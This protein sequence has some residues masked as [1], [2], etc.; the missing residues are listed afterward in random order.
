MLQR[1]RGYTLVEMVVVVLLTTFVF[2]A[3]GTFVWRNARTSRATDRKL[4]AIRAVHYL[5][6]RIRRDMK[7]ALDFSVGDGGR[8]L[9][10]TDTQRQKRSYVYD[11]ES[12]TLRVPELLDPA[13]STIYDLAKFR[14]VLFIPDADG[15]GLGYV[16]SAVPF[17]DKGRNL[18]VEE[19][20]WGSA[21]AGRVTLAHRSQGLHHPRA[22]LTGLVP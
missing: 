21:I 2:G 4:Q 22:N 12:R 18:S 13:S 15:A 3:I 16:I 7:G 10:I 8:Q 14:Q 20:G 9:I 17:D 5:E 19:V 6:G 11:S 1:R